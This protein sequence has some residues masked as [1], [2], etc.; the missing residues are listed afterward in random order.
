MKNNIKIATFL[1]TAATA[2]AASISI[3]P[4]T[5]RNLVN[6]LGQPLMVSNASAQIGYFI[7]FTDSAQQR[8]ALADPTPGIRTYIGENFVPIGAPTSP[9]W[10]DLGQPAANYGGQGTVDVA[11][12]GTPA[13]VTVTGSVNNSALLFSGSA[14][15]TFDGTG[16]PR[17]SRIFLLVW[18]NEDP[19]AAGELGIYSATSWTVPTTTSTT[20]S[21]P[22][23]SVDNA[24]GAYEVYRG[25][26]GSLVLGPIVPEPSTGLLALIAG[27]GLISR[28]RR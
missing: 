26:L 9:L 11:S 25:A 8:A 27:C 23:A 7:G 6:S 2:Q 20:M 16:V 17:G 22:L 4:S 12:T 24:S 21:A 5:T 15:N 18:D 1:I 10:G 28:R 3:L 13:Y 14:A 19:S